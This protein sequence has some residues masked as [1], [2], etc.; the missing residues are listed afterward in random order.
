MKTNA[1]LNAG[2]MAVLLMVCPASQAKTIRFSGYDWIVRPSGAGGPGPNYWSENNV[3]VDQSGNLHLKVTQVNG[4]WYCSEV[5]TSKRLGFGRYQFWIVGRVDKLDPN[6][7]FGLFNYP[8]PDVGPDGTHEIDIEFARW[9]NLSNPIGNYT[10]W[11]AQATLRPTGKTFPISL[12]GNYSTHR[13]TWSPTN[14]YFQSLN[15][16]YDDNRNLF[17]SWLYQPDNPASRIS[18]QAM[19]IHIN[20]WLFKGLPPKNGQPI[21]L[22]VRSFKFTPA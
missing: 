15:G 5:S 16:H 4:R 6:G 22:V 8:T 14:V 18:Q 9:G 7:V 2:V 1:K 11:P 12:N 17:A 21:E 13:F 20:L 3:R 19:P 10:V